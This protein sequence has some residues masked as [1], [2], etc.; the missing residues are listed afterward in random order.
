MGRTLADTVEQARSIGAEFRVTEEGKVMVR[1][2]TLLPPSI[3]EVLHQNRTGVFEYL[4][5]ERHAPPILWETGNVSQ[6]RSLLVL[7]QAELLLAKAQLTGDDYRDWYVSNKVRDL[8][9]KI[10]DLKK[11]LAEAKSEG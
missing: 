1:G 9:I 7:R 3:R 2:L 4:E 10:T 5:V 8:E 11:W 6:L